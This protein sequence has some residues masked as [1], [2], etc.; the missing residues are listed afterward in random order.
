[1]RIAGRE[2]T[3]RW[4]WPRRGFAPRWE[5][6]GALLDRVRFGVGSFPTLCPP[7]KIALEPDQG[8]QLHANFVQDLGRNRGSGVADWARQCVDA[9]H[10]AGQDL[11]GNRQPHWQHDAGAKGANARGNRTDDCELGYSTELGG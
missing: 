8:G 2:N 5:G 3:T 11:P 1:M 7:D 9:A 10:V 6:D 4:S